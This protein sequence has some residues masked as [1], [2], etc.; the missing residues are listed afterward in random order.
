MWGWQWACRMDGVKISNQM[1]WW[2]H[3]PSNWCVALHSPT[4]AR[5]MPDSCEAQLIS[6]TSQAL[7]TYDIGDELSPILASHPKQSLLHSPRCLL[8]VT[9]WSFSCLEPEGFAIPSIVFSRPFQNETHVPSAVSNQ[10]KECLSVSFKTCQKLFFTFMWPCIVTNFFVIKPTTCTNFTNLFC[11]ETL[12]V[13][14]SLS[15]HHQ[16]FIQ[17]TLNNGICHTGL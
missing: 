14:D 9:F 11:H 17:C 3:E 16:E 13:S 8:T 5:F 1:L 12:N 6:N 7:A 2:L 10:G 4:E 15:V